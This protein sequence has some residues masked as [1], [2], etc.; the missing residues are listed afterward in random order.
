MKLEDQR[1]VPHSF[2][3]FV[4]EWGWRNLT[5]IEVTVKLELLWLL[6]RDD[7]RAASLFALLRMTKLRQRRRE[8]GPSPSAA[9]RVRMT[10]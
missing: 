10:N 3:L 7:Q 9:L 2:A 8:A 1:R 4:K 5:E 6:W